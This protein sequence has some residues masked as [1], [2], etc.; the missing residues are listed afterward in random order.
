[1][2]VSYDEYKALQSELYQIGE[3]YQCAEHLLKDLESGDSRFAF[4]RWMNKLKKK[5]M[6]VGE[7]SHLWNGPDADAYCRLV[8]ELY[9]EMTDVVEIMK[10]EA[11]RIMDVCDEENRDMVARLEQAGEDLSFGA[12]ARIGLGG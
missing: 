5:S 12:K 4:I 6:Q 3:Y 7:G 11:R 1:M 10:E 8:E 2:A 9:L